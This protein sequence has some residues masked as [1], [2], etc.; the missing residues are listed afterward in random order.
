[1]DRGG[2]KAEVDPPTSKNE[3]DEQLQEGG[4][5][6]WMGFWQIISFHPRVRDMMIDLASF[7]LCN[8]GRLWTLGTKMAEYRKA[9]TLFRH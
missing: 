3:G 1:M 4:R 9:E 7:Q 5:G 2:Y 8:G 6:G